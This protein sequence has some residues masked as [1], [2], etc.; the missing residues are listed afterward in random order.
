MWKQIITIRTLKQIDH[1]TY[2][3]LGRWSI[4]HEYSIINHKIDQANLDHSSHTYQYEDTDKIIIK[5]KDLVPY[6]L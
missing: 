2:P 4:S 6:C 1:Y 5:E 3:K